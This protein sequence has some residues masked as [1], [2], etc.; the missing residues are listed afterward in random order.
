MFAKALPVDAPRAPGVWAG[1][2]MA[3]LLAGAALP[4]RAQEDLATTTLPLERWRP[5]LDA[6]GLGTTESG[7]V[8]AHLGWDLGLLV[9]YE[10][11]PLVLRD[12]SGLVVAPVVAHRVGGDLAF[13]LGLFDSFALGVDLPLTLVQLGGA[14][15]A[16]VAEVLGVA[17]GFS[18]LG[19]GDLR[20]APKARLL[21]EDRHG[22]SLAITPALTLPTAGGLNVDTGAWTWGGGFLGEG[23]G[24]FAFIPELALS[25]HLTGVRLAGNLAYRL[26]QPSRYLGAL[27]ISPE[28]VYRLGAGYDL[29]TVAPPLGHALL[30]AEIYGATSDQNPFGL[31]P[32]TGLDDDERR[33]AE[34]ESRLT[35]ALEWL[36]GMRWLTPLP[37]LHVEGGIGAGLLPGFGSPDLRA[38][39]GVRLAMEDRDRDDDGV[40]DERDP[41][42]EQAE[43]QDGHDDADGCPDPDNDG[44]LLPD[45]A[46]RCVDV[47]EDKDGF[48]DGDGCPEADNDADGIGDVD[49][50][51]PNQPGSA[52][53]Q[54]CPPPDRDG[55]GVGDPDDACVD[56]PGKAELHG[57][58]DQDQDGVADAEDACP[59]VAGLVAARGCPDQDQ[60]GVADQDDRCIDV[61][62]SADLKGC[63]D[64]DRD[65]IADPDDRCPNEAETINGIDDGDGCPD[66]GKTLVVVAADRIELKETVFF[67]SG[68]D[69][70]QKRSHPLLEQVALVLKA[71]A[72]IRKLSVEG[73][74]D[75]QGDDA[76]NLDLSKRRAASV[77][78]F[79]FDK[80]VDEA[81]LSSEGFGETR[82]I[83]PNKTRAGRE[84]NRRV[85]LRI[86]E[87]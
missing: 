85:E 49:D 22:V 59:T 53:F 25:T 9:G 1:L 48:Q 52:A 51:C 61:A 19:A 44:D 10:L 73:H 56:Q 64:T 8:P 29:A 18:N 68:K 31:F 24:Q 57:C 13:S 38:F 32:P 15:P 80:G 72:E 87:P 36:A 42:P 28:L 63:N 81:R 66:Q 47:A 77:V 3:A 65:G 58:P 4:A 39:L 17:E 6:R 71:H 5:A 78:R 74:T 50:R 37:G 7:E 60:D 41:C 14:L 43:D 35:N 12:A 86:V 34:M 11:N 45:S 84:K 30:F 20:L 82:P 46:D 70:I 69:S 62:G 33:L 79:L 76:R 2:L 54:G 83:A 55:D 23:P 26:R 75:D 67:D 40:E 21:R 27:D 16:D